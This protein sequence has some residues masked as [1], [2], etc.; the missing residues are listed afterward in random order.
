MAAPRVPSLGGTYP[1]SPGISTAPRV[2]GSVSEVSTS[3]I[4]G[5]RSSALTA[6]VGEGDTITIY[7]EPGCAGPEVATGTGPELENSG[8]PVTVAPGSNTI[9]SA[10]NTDATGVSAC[11]NA[12]S[13]QQVN[14]PPAAPTVTAI[15]PA[16]PADN[17]LPHVVGSAD[18]G[19]TVGIFT[20]PSCSGSP[21]ATGSAAVFSAGGI[22]VAVAD[23]STTTFY[24]RASWAELPSPC[25]ST[26]ATFQ[27]V[28]APPGSGGGGGPTEGG[29]TP[30]PGSGSAPPAGSTA[31]A[32][33]KLH[34]V[35]GGQA[36]N[37]TPLV[38]GSADGAAGVQIFKN[39]TCAGSPA[40]AGSASQLTAGFAIQVA[41]NETTRFSGLA[42]DAS[43]KASRCSEPVA[44]TED[45]SPPQTRI[46]F[47]PG[48][49]TH[50]RVAVFR[51]TDITEDPPGTSFLCKFDRAPWKACQAPLRLPHLRTKAHTLRV[52]ATD[53]A[54]NE[55]P[56]ATSW[57]FK[58]I[59]SR[60]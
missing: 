15:N 31:P 50:K 54:G 32:A 23:N 44:Y 60:R 3:R 26:S 38:V 35:P 47:G 57:R 30:L 21:V 55:E 56:A 39:A 1:S 4:G 49:K 42:I 16:S 46:T 5:V 10:T 33:P 19:S 41:E 59:H 52:K 45:S 6:G 48:V 14:N 25:S 40:A 29:G 8:I 37:S 9:F 28:T 36:N 24:A 51:F 43:G 53:L 17:N 34:T 11:S 20:N 12:I 22:P 7:A 18:A 58:V 27:E 13:Y 2:F